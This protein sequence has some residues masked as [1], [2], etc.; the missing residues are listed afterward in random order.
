VES[1]DED[2]EKDDQFFFHY[3]SIVAVSVKIMRNSVTGT[4]F[5]L[6]RCYGKTLLRYTLFR[7]AATF[8]VCI[9][10]VK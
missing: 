3:A 6:L 8:M 9:P 10:G 2:E 5:Y 1:C 7:R 4:H